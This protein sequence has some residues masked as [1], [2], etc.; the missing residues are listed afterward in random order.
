MKSLG[1][2]P[3]PFI[4][5]IAGQPDAV[6]R[7]AAAAIDG[8]DL[9]DEAA[10][11]VRRGR[12]VLSGM[13]SS[14]DACYPASTFLAAAGIAAPMHDAAELLHFRLATLGAPDVL[15]LVSQSGESAETVGVARALREPGRPAPTIVTVT[16][17]TGNTLARHADVALD[18]RAGQEAGPSTMTFV[19][20]LTVMGALA[21]TI[22][23]GADAIR[24]NASEAERAATAIEGLVG[25]DDLPDRLVAWLGSPR[26]TVILGRGAARAA[27]EMGALTVKEAVG[28][29]IEALQTGQFRHGPLELAGPGLAA[30]VIATEPATAELDRSLAEE[31]AR[32]GSAVWFIT[33]GG[34]VPAGIPTID[35]GLLDRLLAPAAAIVPV[36]LLAWRL[37][38]LAGRPPGSY[39][40]ATKVTT[41]E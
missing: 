17:G 34:P 6:R 5:E 25:D 3:D 41:R 10:A 24:S 11:A 32:L 30:I 19:A 38:V 15:V 31:L 40:H 13:G 14:Y 28:T 18:T 16:N 35:V 8:S 27:A 12:I 39:M 4:A 37:S 1:N 26:S 21:R 9:L 7:A 22:A 23:D 2:F 33:A 20:A 29:P 36:Q